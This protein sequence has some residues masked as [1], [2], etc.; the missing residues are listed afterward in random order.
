MAP[1]TAASL[2]GKPASIR[3]NPSSASIRKAFAIPMGTTCTLSITRFAAMGRTLARLPL[4]RKLTG[5][6]DRS[7]FEN[8]KL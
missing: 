5:P 4:Q 2:F 8:T 3:V 6:V 7:S 1:K